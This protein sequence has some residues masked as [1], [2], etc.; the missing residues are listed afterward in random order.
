MTTIDWVRF[1]F[2]G[3]GLAFTSYVILQVAAAMLNHGRFRWLAAAPA[4]FLILALLHAIQKYNASAS[5]WP[6][7]L[8]FSSIAAAVFSAVMVVVGLKR[9][10]RE[11]T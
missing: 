11:K 2:L 6:V 4:P 7:L 9:R 5:L 3:W 8:I 1:F 10:G